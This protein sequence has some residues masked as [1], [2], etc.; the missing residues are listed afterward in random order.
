MKILNGFLAILF[1]FLSPLTSATSVRSLYLSIDPA[2]VLA[3]PGMTQQINLYNDLGN[4]YVNAN[5]W[6]EDASLIMGIG[7]RVFQNDELQINTGFRFIPVS[8]IP[9]KGQIWQLNSPLFYNL[10]YAYHVNSNL[11]FWDNII[12][13]TRYHVQPGIIL[14]LGVASNTTS[15]FREIPIF[16]TSMPSLQTIG[17]KK[18][19][20]FAYELGAVLDYSMQD[21]IF[22]LAYRYINAGYG[23]LQPFTLQNTQDQISTGILQYHLIS[24]G[25]RAYY[26]L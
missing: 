6:R 17:G 22:E 26:A 23:Y 4:T 21:V 25:I 9:L 11:F 2:V 3:R 12:S 20:Q 19:N 14:G 18:T 1:L 24:I 10:D 7:G 8:D 5:R 13:W 16:S 15:A